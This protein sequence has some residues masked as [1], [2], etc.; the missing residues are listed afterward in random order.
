MC[1]GAA[2]SRFKL[3]CSPFAHRSTFNV[4]NKHIRVNCS[5]KLLKLNSSIKPKKKSL[6]YWKMP[7]YDESF[8]ID[9]AIGE[10]KKM[11]S[12]S[13]ASAAVVD[14]N[15][16]N[17]K[18]RKRWHSFKKRAPPPQTHAVYRSLYSLIDTH[19]TEPICKLF[20]VVVELRKR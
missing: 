11:R 1:A 19:P 3:F 13:I 12:Y 4:S 20:V 6:I 17:G 5:I 10:K 14:E 16:E 2:G 18:K 7:Q 9:C 15:C 8:L